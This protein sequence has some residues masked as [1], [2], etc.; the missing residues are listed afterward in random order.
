[1]KLQ[2]L[3]VVA[4]CLM[5]AS[6]A[7]AQRS[8]LKL[9]SA[10][11][12]LR[13]KSW[14]KGEEVTSFEA[15]TVYVVDFWATSCGQCR[16]A[17]PHLT[18][19]QKEYENQGLRIIGISTEEEDVV[20]D[21]V[22]DQRDGIGYTIAVDNR[23]ATERAWMTAAKVSEIPASFIVD[24]KGKIQYIGNPH[25][26]NFAR[27]LELV[28]AGRY[29]AKLFRD[30]RPML[31]AADSARKMRNYRQAFSLLDQVIAVD[32]FIFAPI[33][34]EKFDIMMVDME[35][36]AAAYRY[37][38]HVMQ[39]YSDDYNL[40]VNLGLRIAT[41]PDI[42]SDNRDLDLALELVEEGSKGLRKDDPKLLAMQATVH[43]QRGDAELAASLQ[44]RAWMIAAPKRKAGYE[45][46]LR[47]YQR[48]I[49]S[50]SE[51]PTSRGTTFRR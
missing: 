33:E 25:D 45:R 6:T 44:R 28:V 20:R 46:V 29:D 5:I 48:A 11:P 26:P 19:L 16:A 34:L 50:N 13:V 41:D 38:R 49:A 1:M 42:P 3:F 22:E 17:M 47:N 51:T 4:A 37:A 7:A 15:D 32:S 24:G 9:G 36:P 27:I 21:F 14:I 12:E 10:A 8:T 30:A 23:K 18:E 43:F 2:G 39:R 35:D 40:L 31:D